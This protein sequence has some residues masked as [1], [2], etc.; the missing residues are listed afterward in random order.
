VVRG[1]ERDLGSAGALMRNRFIA[2][3]LARITTDAFVV[4]QGRVWRVYEWEVRWSIGDRRPA[5][6]VAK[7]RLTL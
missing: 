1:R 7:G 3:L 2:W 4:C 6:I 5:S